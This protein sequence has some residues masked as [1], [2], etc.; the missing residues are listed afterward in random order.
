MGAAWERHAM[1]ESA[2]TEHSEISDS[3]NGVHEDYS[4]MGYDD[5]RIGNYRRFG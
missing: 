1:R 2:L 5:V 3:H 4:R